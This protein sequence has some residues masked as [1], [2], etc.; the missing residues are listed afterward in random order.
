VLVDVSPPIRGR[1]DRP[2]VEISI[3]GVTGVR[4]YIQF[5]RPGSHTIRIAAND[6]VRTEYRQRSITVRENPGT[7]PPILVATPI[8]EEPYAVRFSLFELPKK[9]RLISQLEISPD[10]ADREVV[11]GHARI[12]ADLAGRSIVES[13][14]TAV[15]NQELIGHLAR[16]LVQTI[17]A[18]PTEGAGA[19]ARQTVGPDLVHLGA[20]YDWDFGDGTM[21]RTGS[22]HV[23]HSYANAV[24]HQLMSTQFHVSVTKTLQDGSSTTARR[25]LALFSAYSMIKERGILQLPVSQ[26]FRTSRSGGHYRGELTVMNPEDAEVRFYSRILIALPANGKDAGRPTHPTKAF[27][28][29]PARS[30]KSVS[31]SI[32]QTQVPEDSPAFSV[33]FKGERFGGLP[34][35]FSGY[36]EIPEHE[37]KHSLGIEMGDLLPDRL[38]ELAWSARSGSVAPLLSGASV[39][40][41]EAAGS[42]VRRLLISGDAPVLEGEECFPDN[43]PRVIP[44]GLA[45]Q[46]TPEQP[47]VPMPAR[48][49]NARCGDA[50]L[51]PGG[52]T[53]IAKLLTK[54]SPPQRY[55]HCGIMT[56]NL[57]EI[58]HSTSSKQR[59][60][61][62]PNNG[63][64][65][66]IP[67]VP[68]S[69]DRLPAD[70]FQSNA[71]KYQW[72]GVVVQ[73]IKHA[74]EG[75]DKPDPEP[76][77]RPLSEHTTYKIQG[78]GPLPE[79]AEIEG[80]WEIIPP[81]VVKPDPFEETPAVRRILTDAADWACQQAGRSHY[82]LYC[83][84]DPTIGNTSVAPETAG[85]AMGTFPSVCS[86]FVW[87]AL[88][89]AGAVLESPRQFVAPAD[90]EPLDHDPAGAQAVEDTLD[91][92]YLYTAQERLAAGRWLYGEIYDLVVQK[93]EEETYE[94]LVTFLTDAPDDTAS[95]AVN[96]FALDWTDGDSKDSDNWRSTVDANAVSP[97]NLMLYDPPSR[98][99]VYG[100]PEPLVYRPE[101]YE[102]VS[103][104]RWATYEL[105]GSISGLVLHNG[106]P[107]SG[108]S[109]QLYEGKDT[110]TDES[111]GY[112]LSDIPLGPYELRANLVDPSGIYLSGMTSVRVDEGETFA[113]VELRQ[114]PDFYRR[115]VLAGQ[116]TTRDW[117]FWESNKYHTKLLYFEVYLG[118]DERHQHQ[119]VPFVDLVGG[120][121][122][123]VLEVD[124]NWQPD[125]SVTC[126]VTVRLYE[127]E[128][129]STDE[130][131]AEDSYSIDVPAGWW[132]G[133]YGHKIESSG[134]DY[135]KHD[136]TVTNLQQPS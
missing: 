128:D 30:A 124:L 119:R 67:L 132:G 38:R 116:M 130:L 53:T 103:V 77:D 82:R 126:T 99:G 93:I 91:G 29:I 75:E 26:V 104:H 8:I 12:I 31:I 1:E 33:H 123:S 101:R 51:S 16:N 22:P 27:I 118:P 7:S 94:D 112:I 98:G 120:E 44:P 63:V 97:D 79:G 78:F 45:C 69:A 52:N 39:S 24:N 57:D 76:L 23:E 5:R 3:N 43:L 134:G 133:R 111:G 17:E 56:R 72:P 37:P 95:Q 18:L 129:E 84:T 25:S 60:E 46:A 74:I 106:R 109:V 114:P 21:A 88:K 122:R 85:W 11:L 19:A 2:D 117:E 81:I 136:L 121:I 83:Y 100:C 80:R 47:L 42:G 10:K 68:S 62:Y 65:N 59:L 71:L 127:G 35:R 41:G 20:T 125:R 105:E 87:M 55:S 66:D 54:V 96:C 32:P 40:T 115:I 58:T 34:A 49:L 48:F 14:P 73:S 107:V 36:F 28:T 9:G 4:Q 61:A 113:N 13:S 131:D 70:G 110:L 102:T 50:I 6:G 86:S 64:L 15:A 92:L 90:I 89:H 108:A 135:I